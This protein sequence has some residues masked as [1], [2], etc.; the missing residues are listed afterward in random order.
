MIIITYFDEGPGTDDIKKLVSD[1]VQSA[2]ER[3]GV[4]QNNLDRIAIA[5]PENYG[6]AVQDLTGDLYTSN[7]NYI[8]VGKTISKMD[9]GQLRHSIVFHSCIFEAIFTG[10]IESAGQGVTQWDI[11]HQC[12]YFVIPHELGHCR[13]HEE[14]MMP[15]SKR[16]LDFN[17]GFELES[18]HQYYSEILI[19]EVCACYFADKYYSEKMI[20]HRYF[21][22]RETLNQSYDSLRKHLQKYS[23]KGDDLLQLAANASGWIWM[24]QTQLAK[25]LIS[26][27]Y[28]IS[29]KFHLTPLVDIFQNYEE[30]HSF[31]LQALDLVL[32]NYP[33]IPE[34]AKKKLAQSWESFAQ[35]AG[36]TFDKGHNGWNFYWS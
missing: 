1:V 33:K 19:D 12:M 26:S 32:A 36:F 35:R 17:T 21:E 10:Q 4:N 28:G 7:Q 9:Q 24:Y 6:K 13:D 3:V 25:H 5:Y 30:E 18:I 8:S 29:K 14:R 15:T 34:E 20:N 22:E 31:L 2:A 23:G 16:R 11:K 27:S